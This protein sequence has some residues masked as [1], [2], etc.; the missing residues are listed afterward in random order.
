MTTL[1]FM[2]VNRGMVGTF[3][4]TAALSR[5]LARCSRP[6][7]R[8]TAEN[9]VCQHMESGDEGD[10]TIHRADGPKLADQRFAV[11]DYTTAAPASS[12]LS[13][14]RLQRYHSS[15]TRPNQQVN[16]GVVCRQ[17]EYE[18][19]HREHITQLVW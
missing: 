13:E 5:P 8:A 6:V 10:R 3:A 19:P 12:G 1:V 2:S 18:M 11:R 4:R 17:L 9:T 7:M 16:I 15:H 14:R